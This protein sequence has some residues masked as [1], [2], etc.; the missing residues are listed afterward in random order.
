ML[1]GLLVLPGGE[2]VKLG[3]G[4]PELELEVV[5]FSTSRL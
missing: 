4:I 5:A 3:D 2:V 1:A